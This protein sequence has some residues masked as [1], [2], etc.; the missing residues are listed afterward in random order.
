M[1]TEKANAAAFFN[2]E[3]AIT[4]RMASH[5][6][7]EDVDPI[8]PR[9]FNTTMQPFRFADLPVEPTIRILKLLPEV[10]IARF[11]R[12]SSIRKTFNDRKV[13][14]VLLRSRKTHENSSRDR[15]ICSIISNGIWLVQLKV[16]RQPRFFYR[17]AF[18]RRGNGVKLG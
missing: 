17:N 12:V 3:D 2:V 14:N 1:A 7:G 8:L 13:P 6:Y 16:I 10:E 15:S 18:R 11:E 4:R 5:E 9:G